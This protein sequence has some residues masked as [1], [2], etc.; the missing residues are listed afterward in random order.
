M[1]H[2]QQMYGAY[3]ALWQVLWVQRGATQSIFPQV[4]MAQCEAEKL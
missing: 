4:L 2:Q 1:T 3:Q